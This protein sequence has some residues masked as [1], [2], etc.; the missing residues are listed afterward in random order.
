VSVGELFYILAI[1]FMVV[2]AVPWPR[3]SPV[4]LWMLGWA[5]FVVAF[6][7]GGHALVR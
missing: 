4:N 5:C 1:V 7:F 2:A 3:P 6:A